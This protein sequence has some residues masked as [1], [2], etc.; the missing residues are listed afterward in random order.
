MI[1]RGREE[2]HPQST[3]YR[4]LPLSCSQQS[5]TIF[6]ANMSTTRLTFLYP[7]FFR[8]IRACEPK[9]SHHLREVPNPPSLPKAG[10]HTSARKREQTYA[11]RYGPATEPLPPNLRDGKRIPL[12]D[13]PKDPKSPEPIKAEKK[14]ETAGP[15]TEVKKTGKEDKKEANATPDNLSSPKDIPNQP[16]ELDASEAHPQELAQ[17]APPKGCASN[18]PE[19]V[20]QME[21]TTST[22][23]EEHKPPHLQAPPYVHHFDTYSLVKDLETSDF[24]E[25]QSVTLMK[26]V[27]SLLA[28]N[29]DVAKEGLV[30][31]SDVENVRPYPPPISHFPLL[32]NRLTLYP[33]P[34]GNLPLSCRLL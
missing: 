7:Q 2:P 20:L 30:S 26:A 33:P 25:D 16:A 14:T 17:D 34:T 8:S 5:R 28:L 19:T 24:S 11:Q 31:K 10:F 18:P 9:A 29:L 23:S 13:T 15:K 4:Q 12:T 3:R 27:R 6:N 22:E 32:A 1:R 21:S